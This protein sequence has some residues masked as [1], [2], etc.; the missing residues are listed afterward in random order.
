MSYPE[1]RRTK[2]DSFR[3]D[4]RDRLGRGPEM[5]MKDESGLGL[6]ILWVQQA[7]ISAYEDKCPLKP[8]QTGRYSLKW[9]SELE[10]LRKG[11]RWLF[12]KCQTDM[13]LQSWEVYRKAQRI[14]RKDV[15]KA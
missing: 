5:N 10:Y 9:I 12:T 14:Y 1:H 6:A 11:V 4:L 3:E 8:V 13:N 7:L 15:R 2:W